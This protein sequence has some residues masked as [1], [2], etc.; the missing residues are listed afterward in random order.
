MAPR[1]YRLKRRAETTAATRL[2]IIEAAA[3]VYRDRGVSNATLHAI[4]ERADVSRGTVVNHFGGLDGL[5]EAVLDHAVETIVYPTARD[6]D[7]A[8]TLDDRIRRFVDL[9]F[10]F[11]DRSTDWWSVFGADTEVPAIKRRETAYY[12]LFGAF[13]G[14]AFGEL[15]ADRIMGAAIRAFIDYAPWNALREGGLSLDESI[16]VVAD[17]LINVAHKRAD[18]GEGG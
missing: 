4:A 9:T 1:E 2:Q 17:A 16:E 14:A 10:R 13:V 6:L 18:A 5:L 7:G 8:A 15:A 3:A 11:F 12:E